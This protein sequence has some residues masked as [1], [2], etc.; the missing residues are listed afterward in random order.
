MTMDRNRHS[1][2]SRPSFE[3]MALEVLLQSVLKFHYKDVKEDEKTVK[4]LQALMRSRSYLLTKVSADYRIFASL[5]L[6]SYKFTTPQSNSR[7]SLLSTLYHFSFH[8]STGSF[9]ISFL[10][11][12][13]N[14]FS[15]TTTNRNQHHRHQPA[16]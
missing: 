4:K 11:S 2:G 12:P 16:T 10:L 7:N 5:L 6:S 13:L 8:L 1:F 9:S 15:A 14:S 3:L